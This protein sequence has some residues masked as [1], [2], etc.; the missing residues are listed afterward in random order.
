MENTNTSLREI[1]IIMKDRIS[2]E[3]T[4]IILMYLKKIQ[5]YFD[6]CYIEKGNKMKVGKTLKQKL[7]REYLSDMTKKEFKLKFFG[8]KN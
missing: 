6:W 7:E 2:D 8:T 5:C 3:H 4:I 1:T